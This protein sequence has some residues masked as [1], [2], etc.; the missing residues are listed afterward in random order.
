MA[1]KGESVVG[2]VT[3]RAGDVFRVDIGVSVLASLS[4]LA[5]EGATKKNRPN[6]NVSLI[7]RSISRTVQL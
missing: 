2:V 3:Q 6:I 7:M 1:V 4:Y 5:F